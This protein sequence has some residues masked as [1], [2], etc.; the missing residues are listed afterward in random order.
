MADMTWAAIE[1]RD[2]NGDGKLDL[3]DLDLGMEAGDF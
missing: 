2:A 1:E 3:G